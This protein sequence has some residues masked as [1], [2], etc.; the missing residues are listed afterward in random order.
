MRFHIAR[1]VDGRLRADVDG[2]L[3]AQ[4]EAGGVVVVRFRNRHDVA[5][6]DHGDVLQ[7]NQLVEHQHRLVGL[8]LVVLELHVHLVA[9]H[10]TF[11]VCIVD[12]EL[13]AAHFLIADDR[14]RTRERNDRAKMNG[15]CLRCDNSAGEDRKYGKGAVKRAQHDISPESSRRIKRALAEGQSTA[16]ACLDCA[17]LRGSGESGVRE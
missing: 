6:E 13:D 7:T 5:D 8:G 10:A 3:A 14:G 16:I 12:G 11:G 2:D 4:V 9:L 1:C 15:L 17:R